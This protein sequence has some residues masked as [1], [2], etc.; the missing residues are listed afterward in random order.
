[1]WAEEGSSLLAGH[2]W[3]GETPGVLAELHQ[4]TPGMMVALVDDDRRQDFLVTRVQEFPRDG[5]PSW[6]WGSN[7]GDRQLVIVTCAGSP[8]DHDGRR[9]W[10]KN[11]VVVAVP[12]AGTETN[13]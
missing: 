10:S 6:V 1:M 11:L 9:V 4:S 8:T 3:V 7:D 12:T 5:L 13:R 2:V